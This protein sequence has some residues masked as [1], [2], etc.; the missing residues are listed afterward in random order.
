MEKNPDEIPVFASFLER[1]L[2]LPT[3]DLFRGLLDYYKLELVHLNPN[4]IFH[5]AL[6]MHLCEAFLGIRPHFQLF[7]KIFQIKPQAQKEHTIVVG[8]AGIE[9][10]E[11]INSQYFSYSLVDSNQDWKEKWM[12]INNH[13]TLSCLRA[14]DIA[15][16]GTRGGSKSQASMTACK[17]PSC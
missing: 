2:G 8:G 7:R 16:S 15:R 3:S 6:F 13:T 9:M 10:R 5:I 4:G 11:K 12:Y 14:P 1:G 17:Y